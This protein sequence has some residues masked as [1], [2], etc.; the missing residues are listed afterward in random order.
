MSTVQLSLFSLEDGLGLLS[1]HLSPHLPMYRGL[2]TPPPL[3]L[4]RP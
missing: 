3:G 2:G 4:D 1:M